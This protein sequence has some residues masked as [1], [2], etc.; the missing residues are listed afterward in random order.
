MEHGSHHIPAP[1]A[2]LGDSL[3]GLLVRGFR[4]DL[5]AQGGSAH[6]DGQNV[7]DIV[8]DPCRQYAQALHF[9]GFLELGFEVALPFLRLLMLRDI[10]QSAKDALQSTAII[11]FRHKPRDHPCDLAIRTHKTELIPAEWT[12]WSISSTGRRQPSPGSAREHWNQCGGP[13]Q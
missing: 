12:A 2:C 13:G 7:I 1:Q 9:M 11:Q 3:V 8:G 10:G 5:F 6:D 4:G